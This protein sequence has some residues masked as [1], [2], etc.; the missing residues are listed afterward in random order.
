M[1]HTIEEMEPAC[2][3]Y[4]ERT[5]PVPIMRFTLE[6]RSSIEETLT[7]RLFEVDLSYQMYGDDY[8]GG[9]FT[10]QLARSLRLIHPCSVEVWVFQWFIG[11]YPLSSLHDILD[12]LYFTLD[13]C[14][15]ITV[16]HSEVCD[17]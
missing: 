16:T 5:N 7:H 13:A 14:N 2:S 11:F 9:D 4:L 17:S 6:I 10:V 15:F 1:A 3:A 12:H 8:H